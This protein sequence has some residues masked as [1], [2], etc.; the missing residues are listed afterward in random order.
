MIKH[1]ARN[2]QITL[3][4]VG[5]CARE[6]AAYLFLLVKSISRSARLMVFIA[7]NVCVPGLSGDAIAVVSRCAVL[8]RG[9]Y[10]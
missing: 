6:I 4:E 9:K 8:V 2:S 10:S 5:F 7:S 1:L 3:P